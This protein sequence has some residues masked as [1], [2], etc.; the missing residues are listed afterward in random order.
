MSDLRRTGR[1]RF[2]ALAGASASALL[3]ACSGAAS[4]TAAPA[5]KPADTKPADTKPTSAEPTKPA[6]AGAATPAAPAPT[7]AAGAS[8]AAAAPAAASTGKSIKYQQR[9]STTEDF[10]R[11]KY[12]PEFEQKTGTKVVFEDIPANEYFTKVT[13]LSAAKQLGDLVFGYN[14]S[15]YNA[16]WAFKGILAPHD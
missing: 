13:A 4:P 14:S 10:V 15:G 2:L 9:D 6:A 8:P 16:T 5:A 11:K 7:A 12:G 3:A 1:R